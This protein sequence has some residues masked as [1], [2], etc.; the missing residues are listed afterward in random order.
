MEHGVVPVRQPPVAVQA[1]LDELALVA[2]L[3]VRDAFLF[4]VA[5]AVAVLVFIDVA[6]R[7]PLALGELDRLP[8]D[9]EGE[10]EEGQ[11]SQ[12]HGNEFTWRTRCAET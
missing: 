10:D 7:Q 1:G 11:R 8:V 12:A 2:D 6:A 9:G 4:W 5:L 3:D